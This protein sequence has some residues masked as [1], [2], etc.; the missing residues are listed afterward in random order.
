MCSA[1]SSQ[2]R[3]GVTA[4]RRRLRPL[5]GLRASSSY[6]TAVSKMAASVVSILLMDVAPSVPS[7][8]FERRS[9]RPRKR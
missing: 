6:S 3:A 9:H 5:A 8:T 7:R 2:E 4:G 1:R